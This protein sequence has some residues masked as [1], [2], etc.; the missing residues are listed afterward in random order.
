M[1]RGSWCSEPRQN[2]VASLCWGDRMGQHLL[3]GKIGC[4]PHSTNQQCVFLKMNKLRNSCLPSALH[5]P[6]SP[7]KV[8]VKCY[9]MVMQYD[10]L[11]PLD[12]CRSCGAVRSWKAVFKRAFV[13]QVCRQLRNISLDE[14]SQDLFFGGFSG[15]LNFENPS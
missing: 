10:N 4:L 7:C 5:R 6:L 15:S 8:S 9:H 1:P 11:A 3:R 2:P 12:G 13:A 14:I